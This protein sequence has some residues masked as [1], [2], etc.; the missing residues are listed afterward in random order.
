M[1]RN[2]DMESHGSSSKKERQVNLEQK[3]HMWEHKSFFFLW[4]IMLH[5][6][7]IVKI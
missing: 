6:K 5:F 7:G 1:H 4:A 2:P 3:E